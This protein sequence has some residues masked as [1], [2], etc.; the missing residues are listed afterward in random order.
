MTTNTQVVAFENVKLPSFLKP[1]GSVVN[2]F[3]AAG[4]AGGFKIISTKASK[5]H[6]VD[7]DTRTLVTA[8][9]SDDTPASNIEVVIVSSNPHK[10][11]VFYASG[12]TE[13]S[14]DK[15]LCYSNNGVSP[16]ADSAEPQAKKCATCAHNVF[17][18]KIT[19]NGSKAKACAD[20]MRLAVATPDMLNDPMM[21]RVPAASLGDLAKYGQKLALRGVEP[22]HVITRIGFDYTVAFPKLTFDVRKVSPFVTEEQFAEIEQQRDTDVVKQITGVMAMPSSGDDEPFVPPP[23]PKVAPAKPTAPKVEEAPKP[24]PKKP[25]PKPA[26]EEDD[27]PVAPKSKVVVEDAAD[28][29]EGMLDSEDDLEFDD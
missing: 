25:A 1:K 17:G 13:G 2:A 23:A 28:V 22:Q 11:K 27:F 21:L 16:E 6:V 15:P 26:V 24:A 29:V 10:S 20:S 3:A 14:T 12:Y 19:E 7:G 9:G 18:S 4:G 5:F 8:P